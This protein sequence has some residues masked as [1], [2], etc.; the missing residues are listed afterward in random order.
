DD[1]QGPD[2]YGTCVWTNVQ[3]RQILDFVIRYRPHDKARKVQTEPLRRYIETRVKADELTNWTVA[4]VSIANAENRREIAGVDVGL[5]RRQPD[6]D[7]ALND[8]R[9]VLRRMISPTDES[10]DFTK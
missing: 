6:D 10:I 4:V 1:Y 8:G 3:P 5:V 9:Y 7:E 2:K